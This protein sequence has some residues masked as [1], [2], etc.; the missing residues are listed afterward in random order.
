MS[1]KEDALRYT[2]VLYSFLNDV[3]SIIVKIV[4]ENAFSYSEV[5]IWVFDNWFLE[6]TLEFQ[7]L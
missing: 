1:L 7:D 6:I 2:T 5:F 4:K 3:H